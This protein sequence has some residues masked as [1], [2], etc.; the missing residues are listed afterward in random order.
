[1]GSE[2]AGPVQVA[3]ALLGTALD[4]KRDENVI[5]ETWNHTLPYAT[6]CV[7]EARKRGAHPMLLLEDETAYWR[8]IDLAPAIAQWARVGRHEWSALEQADAY[9]FFPGPADRPRFRSL[10]AEHRAALTG[11]NADWYK[12]AEKSRLRGVRCVLGYASEAQSASWGVSAATWRNQL[13]RGMVDVDAKAMRSTADRVAKK[14]LKGKE[15][16]ITAANGTD[17]TLKLRARTPFVDDGVVGPEDLK[18]GNNMTVSPPGAVAVAIDE[19]SGEG[20]AI[21]NRPTF[22]NFGRLEG[23]QWEVHGGR[24][25]SA[26]YSEGQ[27]AF[28]EQY[29]KGPKG[30]EILSVFSLGI[31]PALAAGVPQVEDQEAGAVTLAIG[32]NAAYGGSNKVGFSTWIVLGEAT[33]AVDGAP[34]CDRGHIL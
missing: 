18:L 32:G 4:V 26:W 20:T 21:S 2:E 12:R 5:I 28:D 15:L 27:T 34:L 23:G 11:Y 16:R 25:A 13:I 8:S 24:L 3:Q 17:L 30:K 22:A 33:V 9:V 31:N 1:M 7:V 6:A 10:P 19:R 14:L 29:A